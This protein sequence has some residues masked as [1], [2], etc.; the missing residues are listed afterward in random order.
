MSKTA[1]EK[2]LAFVNPEYIKRIPSLLVDMQQVSLG[3]YIARGVS[4]ALRCIWGWTWVPQQVEEMSKIIN[5][6]WAKDEEAH[7]KAKSSNR[8]ICKNGSWV[9]CCYAILFFSFIAEI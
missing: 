2:V 9:K 5:E 3:E 8:V 4:R 7:P 6:L 1:D